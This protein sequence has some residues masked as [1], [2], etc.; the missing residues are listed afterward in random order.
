MQKINQKVRDT[1][2]LWTMQQQTRAIHI[3][4][5]EPQKSQMIKRNHRFIKCK[6]NHSLLFDTLARRPLI[7]MASSSDTLRISARGGICQEPS[8]AVS[9][10]LVW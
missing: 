8:P 9:A 3:V 7:A 1:G 10:V 5:V 6:G 4:R 2:R